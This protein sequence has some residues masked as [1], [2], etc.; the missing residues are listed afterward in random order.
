MNRLCSRGGFVLLAVLWVMVGVGTVGLA[1]ALAARRAAGTAQNRRALVVAR[2]AAE[3]CLNRTQAI[4]DDALHRARDA[5]SDSAV[6]ATLD[7]FLPNRVSAESSVVDSACDATLRAAGTTIDV[8]SA[9]DTALMRLF[10]AAGVPAARADSLIDA[11]LDWRDADRVP[12]PH[13]AEADWY[14]AHNRLPP[15]DAPFADVRELRLVRG[16]EHFAALDS[17]LG[18]DSDRVVLDRAPLPVI[19]ALPG[20]DAEALAR[21]AELRVR[22]ARVANLLQFANTL[23]VDARAALMASYPTLARL[24]TTE[25]D[26][27]TITARGWSGFPRVKAVVELRLVEAGSR[28]AIVRRRTWAE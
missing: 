16:L 8:N 15:R 17:L 9:D 21:I 5:Q 4:I 19:A 26:A 7:L 3:D 14:V 12:R 27:W 10:T 1:L 22:G 13:G 11:I 23:S 6:W 28:A 18:V 25:P 24:T 2:W 20:L